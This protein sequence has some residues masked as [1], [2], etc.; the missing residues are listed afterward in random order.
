[1]ETIGVNSLD[2]N[3]ALIKQATGLDE[4]KRIEL[5][6]KIT[7]ERAKLLALSKELREY[8]EVYGKIDWKKVADEAY[9]LYRG[10]RDAK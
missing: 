8:L 5:L 7:E 10:L 3:E 4:A 6:S 1:M 9:T 2:T